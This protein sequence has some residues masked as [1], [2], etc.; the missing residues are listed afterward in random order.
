MNL[1][2]FLMAMAVA[3]PV[4]CGAE[5]KKDEG[6]E[7]AA[8]MSYSLPA[9][10]FLFEV[11]AEVESFHAGAYAKFAGKYLGIDVP[12]KDENTCRIISVKV[13][14]YVEADHTCRYFLEQGSQEAGLA[15]L[16]LTSCGLVSMADSHSGVETA[17]R[18]PVN[19]RNDAFKDAIVSNLASEAA[20]L[21]RKGENAYSRVA[22]Q[23]NVMV[24]KTLEQKAAETASLI[25]GLR[26]KRMQII[27]GDTDATY[28]GEAMGAA[29]EEISRLEK[30]YMTMF[31]GYS[32]VK[33]QKMTFDIVPE[34]DRKMYVAF[35][36]SETAG[37][38][39]AD[40]ISGKPVALE[41]IPQNLAEPQ[42]GLT[43]GS[44]G[45]KT[46]GSGYIVYRVP[47]VCVI[48]LSEGKNLLFQGRQ[49]IYQFGVD[50]AFPLGL[51]K[52]KK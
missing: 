28:S 15:F 39:P 35:R 41:I 8:A 36:I 7:P 19:A 13:T 11:E 51:K 6:K 2:S 52:S 49:T 46:K 34:K 24:A 25:F 1:K 33:V 37:L 23:Q 14:P 27:T 42:N 45:K 31:T 10:S 50:C 9:T 16:Q 26:Q 22:V 48:K 12:Q 29:V 30:E 18:F 40:D 3:A 32:E 44:N 5:D 21:Y 20:T 43:D 47:A 38:L 4:F 17:W